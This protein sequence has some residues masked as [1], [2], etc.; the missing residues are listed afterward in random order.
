M[1]A[2]KPSKSLSSFGEVQDPLSTRSGSELI[3]PTSSATVRGSERMLVIT[4]LQRIGTSLQ[5]TGVD[6]KF[7][8]ENFSAPRGPQSFGVELR[9]ARTD[10]PGSEEPVEQVLGWNYTPFTV[11]GVWDDRH[12]GSGYAEQTRKDFEEMVQR[13]NPIRYE[14]EQLSITGLIVKF[15]FLYV[16]K[17]YQ[18]YSFTISPHFRYQGQTV[19]EDTN[20]F[21]KVFTDPKNAVKK[22]RAGLDAIKAAQALASAASGARIQQLLKTGVFSDINDSL[23]DMETFISSSEALVD[24]EI[25]GPAENASKALNRGAQVMASAKTAAAALLNKQKSIQASSHMAISSLAENLKFEGWHRTL[26]GS[27]RDFVVQA[28]QSRRDFAYRAQPKPKRLHRVRQGESLYQI[29]TRY[30][31]TPHHWREIL[32]ANNLNAIVLNGGELL[33]IP[34]LKL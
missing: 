7:A 20:K 23:D 1:A 11:R 18:T 33:E 30:Y 5:P 22:A 31:G 9:T 6:F 12:A 14:F 24:N 16:R 15:E 29:S 2:S 4:E 27:A 26:A 28:E 32:Q 19:R 13:G 34:E 3:R 17:D 25:L 10:L 21:R 8:R